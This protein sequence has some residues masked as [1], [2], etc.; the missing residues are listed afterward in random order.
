MCKR[1]F[2][3]VNCGP[4][5]QRQTGPQIEWFVNYANILLRC[6]SIVSGS[7]LGQLS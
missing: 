2:G 1:N 7:K 5:I 3:V 6:I 4:S